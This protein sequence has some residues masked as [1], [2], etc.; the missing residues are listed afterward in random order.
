MQNQLIKNSIDFLIFRLERSAILRGRPNGT[1]ILR[2]ERR[3]IARCNEIW[4]KQMDFVIK[5]AENISAL[6]QDKLQTN[7]IEDEVNRIVNNIPFKAAL[8]EEVVAHMSTSMDKGGQTSVKKLKLGKFGISWDIK[9]KEAITFLN[10]KKTLE[11]SNKLGTI[12][13]TTKDRIKTILLDAANS[14][15]SYQKTAQLIAEQGEAGVFSHARA[16]MIATREIGV[17]YE[18]GN[19]IPIHDFQEKYPDRPV[20]KW[21]RTVNDDRVTP[22][23]QD[24]QDQSDN[25]NGIDLDK[26]FLSGDDIAP[27]Y[28]NPRCRCHTEYQIT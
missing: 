22:E 9:N 13:A 4:K 11:L 7:A 2:E 15:Q 24:N 10:E 14:G 1:F 20:K 3:L 28:G 5:Q 6:K 8:V 23:C 17:A 21:W 26:S 18:K 25:A 19:N 27:R 16:Q 12:H